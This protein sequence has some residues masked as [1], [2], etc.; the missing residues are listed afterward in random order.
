MNPRFVALISTLGL[1]TLASIA[2]EPK[3]IYIANDDHTDFMWTADADTYANVFVDML[4][5]HMR[6]ADAT[7][8]NAPPYRNRFNADGSYW[9][10]NYE[11]K[12]TPAEFA[13]LIERLKDGTISAP[14]T[15]LVSCYGGQPAEA[16]LRGMYYAGRLERR[17]NLRFPMA[18][19]MEDQTLPLGLASLFA[20]S[21]ARYSWRGI[22]N[23]ATRMN[24]KELG[25][26][27][28]EIYWWTGRDG[29]RL[30]LKWYS[31]GPNSIGTYLEANSPVA[32]IH[33][34]ETDAGF[35]RRYSDPQTQTPYDVVGL[36]GFG[37]DDLGRKTGIAPPP[38]IPAVPGLAKVISS[39]YC[40]HFHM[41]AQQQSNERRQIIVSNEQDFFEDFERTHGA[42][43]TAQ[44]VTHGNEWDLYSA[45]MSETS[46]RAKRALEK[47]RSAELLAAMVSLKYPAFMKN[48]TAARDRAFN[49]LG[50]YWEHNWTADGPISRT[51]R[52]AWEEEIAT[53]IEFYVN[54]IQGEAIVRLG[55]LI[56][57]PTNANRFFVLNPLGW[58]RTEFA[59]FG[60]AGSANIHVR[61]V[62][63]GKDVP[64]QIVKL[65]GARFLRI[66][67][68]EIPSAGYK[69]FQIDSGE[70][71]APRDEAAT[72][73]NDGGS[74]FENDAV[75]LVIE[76]SGAIRS[77]VD[78]RR[79]HIELAATID[80]LKLNDF[81][82]NSDDGE[83]LRV[84]NRGPVSLTVRAR[85]EA[86]LDHSTAITLYRDSDR[87]DIR[88]EINANFSDVR[89]W[90][91]SF[92][93]S[94]PALHTEEVGAVNLNRLKSA[95]GDYADTHARY[96]HITVNHFADFTDGSGRKGITLSNPDLAFAKLGHSTVTNLD[97]ATPQLNMLAGGQADGSWLGIPGQNGNTRFLQRF[98]LR[99]HGAYDQAA[100]MK[101]A[102]E[103]QNPLVTGAVLSKEVGA[104]PETTY[105]LL[106]VSN[107]EV[108][109]WALKLHEDGLEQGLV[110]RLWNISDAPATAEIAV[111][112][113]LSAAHRTTHVETDIE[114]VPLTGAGAL[115][116]A[117]ARQQ[118]Q[119][120]RLKLK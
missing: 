22:C 64:H 116:A 95:G 8:T 45:S 28:R 68:R 91:F 19:A 69:V 14:L 65:D 48:H 110:A 114:P 100:A 9:L 84:E 44:S 57:R 115:P 111:T 54:S 50:L 103:H 86:G 24:Q 7:A 40:D 104:Y 99:A 36:F 118:M 76:R 88:N 85:S 21:G 27:P 90:T 82:T 15:T 49:D 52:A 34:V 59:D 2:A 47:L 20:G 33:Y 55:G 79:G 63:T 97:T 106:A 18:I 13:R 1:A 70:G 3:R 93:L 66:L 89:Y 83:P 16:V 80:N 58:T 10:W 25:E 109:L 35:A 53:E 62:T 29:Q 26:R 101:F 120:Y 96:D 117:F 17:Y 119:T 102:L 6:L 73:S 56:A 60:Y 67:A 108:L 51:H 112:P 87:V 42:T 92:A 81:A 98:A 5:W 113:G 46:A 94:E 4:D 77:F 11:Q 74:T 12:K 30:L 43:L 61:D 37:G 72:F 107:P 31:A 105:S 78:K 32:A 41:I 23:C 75:K 38:T 39:P 71:A